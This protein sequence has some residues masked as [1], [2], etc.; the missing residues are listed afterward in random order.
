[1]FRR[2]VSLSR[3]RPSGSTDTMGTS[4]TIAANWIDEC[5]LDAHA[6]ATGRFGPLVRRQR[7][8][9]I[10]RGTTRQ[11]RQESQLPGR[12]NHQLCGR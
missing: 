11:R 3:P 12:G 7:N 8:G 1:V 6:I 9:A 10:T 4:M 2:S 5:T